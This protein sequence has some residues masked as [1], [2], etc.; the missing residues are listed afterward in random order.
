MGSAP[1]TLSLAASNFTIWLALERR[2]V[3]V[4]LVF[5]NLP[6][7]RLPLAGGGGRCRGCSTTVRRGAAQGGGR[8]AGGS[9]SSLL[10][11]EDTGEGTPVAQRVSTAARVA[12]G[13]GR[14]LGLALGSG[15]VVANVSACSLPGG[16]CAI[17]CVYEP[18]VFSE[19]A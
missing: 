12:P 6:S 2:L 15:A 16:Q 3:G 8:A 1:P 9:A 7:R 13:G 5:V 11:F 14:A 4:D 17:A 18:F 10:A 19:R